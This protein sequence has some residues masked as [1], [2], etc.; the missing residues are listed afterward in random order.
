MKFGLKTSQK[1]LP[2]Q[3]QKVCMKIPK[4]FSW[5][6][7]LYLYISKTPTWHTTALNSSGLWLAQAA[8]S[9]PPLLPPSIA[10]LRG[11]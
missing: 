9:S 10:S 2:N 5:I 7:G 3:K 4:S 8:T 6:L 1:H 11:Y